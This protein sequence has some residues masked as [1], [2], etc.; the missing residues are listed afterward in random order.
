ML[1]KL[2]HG[3]EAMGLHI[4]V[5]AV[6]SQDRMRYKRFIKGFVSMNNQRTLSRGSD[7][8]KSRL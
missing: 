6:N 5:S 8:L 1:K 4:L 2:K 7:V 3:L